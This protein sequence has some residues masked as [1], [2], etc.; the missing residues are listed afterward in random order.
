MPSSFGATLGAKSEGRATFP[1]NTQTTHIRKALSFFMTSVLEV[2]KSGVQV[3]NL[4]RLVQNCLQAS[5]EVSCAPADNSRHSFVAKAR[6]GNEQ[7]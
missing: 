1:R 6:R 3:F 5:G 4:A 2:Q 7:T